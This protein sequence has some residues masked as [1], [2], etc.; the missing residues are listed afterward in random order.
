MRIQEK[1]GLSLHPSICN[2]SPTAFLASPPTTDLNYSCTQPHFTASQTPIE[3]FALFSTLTIL[4]TV[5]RN[6]KVFGLLTRIFLHGIR[7]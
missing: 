6:W 7:F 3:A 2:T 1:I 4:I 5:F